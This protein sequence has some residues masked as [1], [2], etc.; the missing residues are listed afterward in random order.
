MATGMTHYE[1][2]GVSVRAG[3]DE[4]RAAYRDRL[5]RFRDLAGS[6]QAPDPL[7]LDRLREA[8]AVLVDPVQRTAY[9]A[10]LDQPAA[11]PPVPPAVRSSGGGDGAVAHGFRFVGEGGAYFRIWIVNL[12]LS[13]VTLGIYSAWAK[14]RRE[15]YFHRNLLFNDSAFDYHG[16]PQAIL[17]GRA[18]A[19]ALFLVL[20]LAQEAGPL[21]YLLALLVIAIVAPALLI[22]ALRF[23]AANT[24]YRSL[25]FSFEATYATA[26]KV[27]A[28][29]LLITVLTLGLWF[30][31]LVR[32]WRKFTVEHSR[33]GTTAF[34]CTLGVG[35]VY[36]IFLIPLA[37]F[38][39]LAIIIGIA[40]LKGGGLFVILL[41]IGFYLLAPAYVMGRLTNA[42]W[43]SSALGEHRFSSDIPVRRYVEVALTNWLGIICTLGL[44]IPWA[45]VRMARLRAAHLT[46]HAVGSLDDFVAREHEQVSALGDAAAD[47]F[48]MDLAL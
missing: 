32:D 36:R 35:Q 2:L 37:L 19:F 48:D 30:P 16:K 1:T 24:S 18:I 27:L 9:D 8:Y 26:F 7:L 22:R 25:R 15:Q 44:F 33:F 3:T 29:N 28:L 21:P 45:Q 40:G 39:V 34:T 4:I 6:P 42:V 38:F 10:T 46:L 23:R 17:K 31:K 12:C 13:I 43:S 5:L 20:S 41:G 47:V 11:P 14:V